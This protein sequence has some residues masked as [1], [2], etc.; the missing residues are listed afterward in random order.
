[1]PKESVGPFIDAVY[2]IAITILA[3]E[4]PSELGSDL[5]LGHFGLMLTEYSIAFVLLFA[6]WLQHR[7]I[8][9]HIESYSRTSIWLTGGILLF[10]CLLPRA[11]KFVF[12]YGED[13]TISMLEQSAILGEWTV[14]EIANL[15]YVGL[16]LSADLALL[17]LAGISTRGQRS[18][19]AI[20]VRRSK[21]TMSVIFVVILGG[22][23]LLEVQNRYIL[24]LLPLALFFE[25]ELLRLIFGQDQQSEY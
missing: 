21:F 8:N 23:F 15:F 19:S 20:Y 1:M 5:T 11:T 12:Q 6:L 10:I 22:S 18:S 14:G 17:A 2:A 13:V 9:G 24:L 16:V 4:V 25:R 7:R 3:L